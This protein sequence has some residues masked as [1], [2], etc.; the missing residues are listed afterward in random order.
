M[1]DLS[2][3][4]GSVS[5]VVFQDMSNRRDQYIYKYGKK[6]SKIFIDTESPPPKERSLFVDSIF[7]INI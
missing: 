3:T 7:F 1:V 6:P 2:K 5:L 4:D